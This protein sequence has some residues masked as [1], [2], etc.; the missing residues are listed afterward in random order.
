MSWA[1][2][3]ESAPWFDVIKRLI[4]DSTE[5][6]KQEAA[7]TISL[8]WWNFIASRNRFGEICAGYRLLPGSTL[9]ISP[10]AAD[11]L[12][13]SRRATDGYQLAMQARAIAEQ[14]LRAKLQELGFARNLTEKQARN[15]SRIAALPAGATFSVPG[16]GKTTEALATFFYRA[17]DDERLLVIAPKNAFAAWDEQIKDCMPHLQTQFTRLRG[18]KER[19]A[20]LLGDDP[21]WLLITYQQLARVSDLVAAH[22]AQRKTHVFLDESHR[23]KSGVGRQT[24]RAALGLAHLP[25]G[26]LIMSGTPMPQDA[27]DLIPQFAFLYPEIPSN[28]DTVIELIKP[29]YVRTNKTELGLPPV[30]RVMVP[31][32]M[33]PMQSELYKLMKFE[34]SREA[35]TALNTR[36]KQAFRSLGRSVARL[37]QFVSNPALLSSEISFAHP[38]LL[39]GV[40]AEG[41]GPKLKYV[42]KRARQLA[43]EGHKVLIWSSF[44]RNV[45]FIAQRLADLG[46]V[47]IHGGVDAGD[48]DD[49]ETREGKIKLFHDDPNVR[50]MVANPAAASEGVSLHRV[51]HHA[52][53]LDRTFNAAHYLQSEDRIHRFGLPPEQKT[54][55]EIVECLDSV[56]ETVR[57]RLGLKIG[58]MAEALDDSSLRPDPIA[59]DPIDI[60]DYEEYSTGLSS[61]DIEALLKDFNRGQE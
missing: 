32:P 50:I 42:L 49:D 37:L 53:Y 4:L 26:K 56:D 14:Q 16:A 30:D 8:P 1:A 13:Q 23:I 18:G 38:D 15:V 41:D 33:A 22:V 2:P 31:L 54:R 20:K 60:E 25:V 3:D 36:S 34:V 43:R 52:L 29:V 11:L 24:A 40:L 21:R 44:V 46:A 10:K 61:D 12:R 27:E 7:L 45:E 57:M 9:G 48:E 6:A 55:I 17:N 28:R 58:A 35:A 47:Y 39:A 51:C 19:I 5:D 59:L